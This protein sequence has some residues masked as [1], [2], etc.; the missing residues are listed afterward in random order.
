VSVWRG[1]NQRWQQSAQDIQSVY[2][3]EIVKKRADDLTSEH[4][5][6]NL[7]LGTGRF[8]FVLHQGE[9]ENR[10]L[11]R[12][13]AD[14]KGRRSEEIVPLTRFIIASDLQAMGVYIAEAL[15]PELPCWYDRR[16]T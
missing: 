8:Q 1:K 14:E 9:P 11:H 7:H 2:V 6:I 3:S 4:G 13:P 16:V 5:E 15:A 10:A 12:Q